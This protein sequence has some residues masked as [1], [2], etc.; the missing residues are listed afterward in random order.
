MHHELAALLRQVAGALCAVECPSQ[1]AVAFSENH[2]GV[3]ILVEN[4]VE[5]VRGQVRPIDVAGLAGGDFEIRRHA[6][7]DPAPVFRIPGKQGGTAIAV[8]HE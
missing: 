7:Q 1:G 8:L 2:F 3:V 4:A 6:G 5:K